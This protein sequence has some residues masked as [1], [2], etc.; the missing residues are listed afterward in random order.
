MRFINF[1]KIRNYFTVNLDYLLT[2]HSDY[3]GMLYVPEAGKTI[4][5]AN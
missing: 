2:I 1:L 5:N 3:Q 4:F